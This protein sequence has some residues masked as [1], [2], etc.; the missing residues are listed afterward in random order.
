[1]SRGV[2][3]R[4]VQRGYATP[5]SASGVPITDTAGY[6]AG[7]TVEAAL[8]ELGYRTD[9]LAGDALTSG[10]TNQPR[11]SGI[12]TH[13]ATVSGVVYFSY[14]RVPA[15][16]T[17]A[18]IKMYSGSTAAG[19]T[20]TLV[21]FGLYSVA[22]NGDLTRIAQTASDTAIFA[23]GSTAYTRALAAS[24]ALAP[25]TTYASALLITTGAALPTVL[26]ASAVTLGS[27]G[28]ALAVAPRLSS[29]FAAQTDL[30]DTVAAGS[31]ANATQRYFA[32]ITP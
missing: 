26:S 6:Y 30:A 14:F 25:G 9:P 11:G 18:N 8:T 23:S 29:S 7:S 32:E 13:I 24:V 22:A 4:G 2:A 5:P 15:A 20:P 31:L 21:K 28:A 12:T 19:A 3:P 10:V 17:A 27:T 16:F 1:M